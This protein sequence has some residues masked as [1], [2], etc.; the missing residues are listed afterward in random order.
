[1][2]HFALLAVRKAGNTVSYEEAMERYNEDRTVTP[3]IYKT[4]EELA[5]A[6]RESIASTAYEDEAKIRDI[7]AG[8][9]K[10]DWCEKYKEKYFNKSH[11][12]DRYE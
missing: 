4:Y 3:Y 1:M 7:D 5:K 8:M 10:S 6:G 11:A 2:S 9:K 12:E